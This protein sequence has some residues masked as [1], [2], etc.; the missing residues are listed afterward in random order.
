MFGHLSLPGFGTLG[1]TVLGHSSFADFDTDF[2]D[3]DFDTT[4]VSFESI[5]DA[6][7]A[8]SAFEDIIFGCSVFAGFGDSTF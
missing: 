4:F 7:F 2:K 6:V 8:D 3:V 1:Y 5:E